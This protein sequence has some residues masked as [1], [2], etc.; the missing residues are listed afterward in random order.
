MYAGGTLAGLALKLLAS[1]AM[2][3]RWVWMPF[4]VGMALALA[5][6]V[7]D[8]APARVRKPLAGALAGLAVGLV[9]PWI[10]GFDS[11]ARWPELVV[12]AREVWHVGAGL[13]AGILAGLAW[14]HGWKLS[15]VEWGGLA[16]AGN[17]AWVAAAWLAL[18]D[19]DLAPEDGRWQW[20]NGVG[21]LGAGIIYL[22]VAI[23]GRKARTPG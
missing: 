5:G 4:Q 21:F 17:Q 16:L 12:Q 15:P 20:L 7:M 14:V 22:A 19:W 3:T 6:M 23:G 18:R 1:Y 8:A 10:L 13:T 2:V 11:H 9:G